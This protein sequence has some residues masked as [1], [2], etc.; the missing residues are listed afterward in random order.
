MAYVCSVPAQ[1]YT[2]K[3]AYCG[4]DHDYIPRFSQ[5]FGIRGILK[6]EG[7]FWWSGSE[8]VTRENCDTYKCSVMDALQ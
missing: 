6:E 3:S 7:G 2:R 8:G 5:D 1:P 4:V